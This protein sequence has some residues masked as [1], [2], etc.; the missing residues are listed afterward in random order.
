MKLVFFND[1]FNGACHFAFLFNDLTALS[2]LY[3]AWLEVNYRGGKVKKK[4]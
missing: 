3:N 4:K 2:F 1:E